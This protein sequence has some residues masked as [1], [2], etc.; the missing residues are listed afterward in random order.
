MRNRLP[1]YV[2]AACGCFLIGLVVCGPRAAVAPT[3]SAPPQAV[4]LPTLA[5]PA[6][7]R[8]SLADP[9]AGA[10]SAAA[11]AAPLPSRATPAPYQRLALPDP[12]ENRRP[13]RLPVP[14]EEPTPVAAAPKPPQP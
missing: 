5:T 8:A 11:V 10:S 6:S 1:A 12:Y 2:L 14:D 9:T 4:P 7:D 13:L 3:E